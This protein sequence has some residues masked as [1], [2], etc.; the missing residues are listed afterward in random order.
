MP[1]RQ[2]LTPANRSARLFGIFALALLTF[3]YPLVQVFEKGNLLLGIPAIYAYFFITWIA[4]II[5]IFK[6]LQER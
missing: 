5:L 3:N 1:N 6:T 4:L 2:H